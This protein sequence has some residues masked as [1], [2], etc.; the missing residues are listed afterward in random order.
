MKITLREIIGWFIGG[1]MGGIIE[2][3]LFGDIE[4]VV[5]GVVGAFLGIII[6]R[7]KKYGMKE[8][9]YKVY[10]KIICLITGNFFSYF[11]SVFQ[12]EYLVKLLV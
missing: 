3:V 5:F 8:H 11:L 10:P 2:H 7:N 1:F 12:M 6:G 9:I 4:S